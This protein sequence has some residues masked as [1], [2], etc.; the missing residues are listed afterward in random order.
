MSAR[1]PCGLVFSA[2]FSASCLRSPSLSL[3][4]R[5]QR[6]AFRLLNP[7]WRNSNPPSCRS[8]STMCLASCV[9]AC[10]TS[11]RRRTGLRTP[12][13]QGSRGQRSAS[14]RCG[15]RGPMLALTQLSNYLTLEG[16]FSAVSKPNFESKYGL[17]STRRD[18]QNALL[19][20]VL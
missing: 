14:A 12:A 1:R 20:T 2:F 16:S 13:P 19:C 18:L 4:T 6:G 10:R 5:R 9:A 15:A 8:R 11:S 7:R 3:P 17:E